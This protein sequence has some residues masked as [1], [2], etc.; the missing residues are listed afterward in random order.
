MLY[1][2]CYLLHITY[3]MLLETGWWR[4]SG[5]IADSKP[6]AQRSIEPLSPSRTASTASSNAE[7]DEKPNRKSTQI[8]PKIVPKSFQ[9]RSPGRSG[10][11]RGPECRPRPVKSAPRGAPRGPESAPRA[12]RRRPRG[13]Q[14]RPKRANRPPGSLEKTPRERQSRPKV[15]SEPSRRPTSVEKR[16]QDHFRDDFRSMLRSKTLCSSSANCAQKSRRK[17]LRQL[18]RKCVSYCK[19]QCPRP[20]RAQASSREQ[21]LQ[22]DENTA[23]SRLETPL[24]KRTELEAENVEKSTK[25][26]RKIDENRPKVAPIGLCERLLA[27][28]WARSAQS[29]GQSR[30]ERARAGQVERPKSLEE[31]ARGLRVAFFD[32]F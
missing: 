8:G 10:S 26:R 17:Q 27:L 32:R 24:A 11:P 22:R 28:E 2:I 29:S 12:S 6:I 20:I 4:L 31:V 5:R 1:I 23:K 30:V 18:S 14:E 13:A 9:N 16:L 3:C 21:R 25:N 19:L 15:G 7:A